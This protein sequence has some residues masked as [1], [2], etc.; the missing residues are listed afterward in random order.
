MSEC[1]SDASTGRSP[2]ITIEGRPSSGQ[3]LTQLA[4]EGNPVLLAFSRG[5]DSIAAW[6]A[7]R[8]HGIEVVPY[9]LYSIPGLRFVAESLKA[10]EDFF[11]TK[12][13]D[14]PHP[15]LY[16]WLTNNVFTPPERW[17]IIQASGIAEP[18]YDEVADGIRE[19]YDLPGAW[20]IDGVRA[21]DSPMRRM[22]MSTHGPVR[23]HMR[24]MSVIWDWQIA[25]IRAALKRHACPL[26][27]DYEWFGRS[28][29]GIDYRF[30][31]PIRRNA[32]DDYA[33][34]ASWFPLVELEFFRRDLTR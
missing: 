12:I 21:A 27:I 31:E 9:H 30:L 6:L 10:F 3:L 13:I 22:A 24:K 1:C 14:L 23:E 20:N 5:K 29:D 25:D 17:P 2:L 8:E 18:T 15:A 7:L 28:Y 33:R 4:Q 16:R 19:D 32:P 34:I 11:D 26:P